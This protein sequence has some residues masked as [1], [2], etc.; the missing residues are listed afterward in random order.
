MNKKGKVKM[1]VKR[2]VSKKLKSDINECIVLF[3]TSFL[4]L[5]IWV[6]I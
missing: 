3:A 2:L 6:I 4:F 5:F 1:R